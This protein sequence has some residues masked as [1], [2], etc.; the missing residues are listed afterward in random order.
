MVTKLWAWVAAAFG[1]MGAALLYVSGQRDR[2]RE[3]ASRAKAEA[4][5]KSA[6]I[7]VERAID[8]ARAQARTQSKETQREAEERPA[9]ER[10]TGTFRR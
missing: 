9:D 10:P 8:A 3:A 2:A 5:S 7:D 1:L 6:I 4:K